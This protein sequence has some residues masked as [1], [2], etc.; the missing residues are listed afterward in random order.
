MISTMA[1]QALWCF[2][3]AISKGHHVRGS[4]AIPFLCRAFLIF[5]AR[6]HLCLSSSHL[7]T[8]PRKGKRESSRNDHESFQTKQ[9]DFT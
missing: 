1:L 4:I 5:L 3:V 8:S 6:K 7:E 9:V 2:S